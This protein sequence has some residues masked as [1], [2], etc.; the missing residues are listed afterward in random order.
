M[1][2]PGGSV[3]FQGRAQ[4]LLVHG[5]ALYARRRF[6]RQRRRQERGA[7]GRVQQGEDIGIPGYIRGGVVAWCSIAPRDSYRALD[8]PAD[9]PGE[10]VWS[11]VCFFVPR[12]LRTKGIARGL[13]RAAVDYARE[14]GAT[15]VEAYPVSPDSPSY[16]FIGF[17]STFESMGF[18]EVGRAGIRLHV[19]RLP[20]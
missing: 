14:K 3:R 2:R 10:N 7:A 19:M 9:A 20:V 1:P 16:R 4:V 6:S 5:M 8:G 11:I 18:L 12:R 17:I 13:V 15:V